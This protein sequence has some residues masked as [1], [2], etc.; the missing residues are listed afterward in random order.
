M[1]LSSDR[2]IYNRYS[3]ADFED[4]KRQAM[5]YRVMKFISG[6]ALTE[7]EAK[8]RYKKVLRINSGHESLGLFS[9]RKKEDNVV[10][11]LAKLVLY[12]NTTGTLKGDTSG[13]AEVGYS[14]EPDYWGKGY[15]T[16]ITNFFTEYAKSFD[17]ITEIVGFTD[18]ENINSINV[19]KKC[20]YTFYEDG[21]WNGL[22]TVIYK[23]SL[24]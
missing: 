6:K 14:L 21:L 16:E 10:V 7:E 9:V 5:D 3:E 19:L 20:G 17:E 23:L 13:I 4:Y 11:G 2:L 15:A 12:D 24:R 22:P 1:Q 18:P 8:E